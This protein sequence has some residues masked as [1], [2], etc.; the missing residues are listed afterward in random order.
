MPNRNGL[1]L[2]RA[3]LKNRSIRSIL[4]FIGA[5]FVIVGFS[6]L[7]CNPAVP[8]A[9][10]LARRVRSETLSAGLGQVGL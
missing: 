3:F 4:I 7:D 9:P 2:F 6:F 1:L 8:T 5:F 10:W